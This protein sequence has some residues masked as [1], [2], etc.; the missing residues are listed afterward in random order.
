MPEDH[1]KERPMGGQWAQQQK[2][3]MEKQK[4]QQG[5]NNQDAVQQGGERTPDKPIGE[6]AYAQRDPTK[7]KTGE[8]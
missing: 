6:V 1:Q 2:K 7:K 4:Q 8:F 5:Q 3:G